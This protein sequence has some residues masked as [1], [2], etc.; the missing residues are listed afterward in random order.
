M[1]LHVKVCD[2]SKY[3]VACKLI[4]F[5]KSDNY[6]A[7]IYFPGF[8]SRYDVILSYENVLNSRNESTIIYLRHR[9]N[10]SDTRVSF[11]G[12]QSVND[13]VTRK[14]REGIS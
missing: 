8:L 7:F 13:T 2:E 14:R 10:D 12:E 6:S 1:C 3:K 9:C 4:L 11:R 5:H